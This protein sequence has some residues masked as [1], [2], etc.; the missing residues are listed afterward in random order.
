M[1]LSFYRIMSL[2]YF[3][4]VAYSAYFKR[5]NLICHLVEMGLEQIWFSNQRSCRDKGFDPYRMRESEMENEGR[6][7]EHEFNQLGV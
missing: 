6:L 1:N 2:Y 5:G 4:K 7:G 3:Q